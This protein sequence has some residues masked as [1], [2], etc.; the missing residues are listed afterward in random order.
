MSP[1]L[2]VDTFG[3]VLFICT[4]S[5]CPFTELVAPLTIPFSF[6][7]PKAKLDAITKKNNRKTS[8]HIMPKCNSEHAAQVHQCQVMG[9]TTILAPCIFF[10]FF[11]FLLFFVPSTIKEA[12]T[13]NG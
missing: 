11:F 2:T 4:V 3:L 12:Y 10:F 1:F 13:E 7:H 6:M 5:V 8:L 9:S